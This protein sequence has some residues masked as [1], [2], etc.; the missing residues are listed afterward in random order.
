MSDPGRARFDSLT[1]EVTSLAETVRRTI[2]VPLWQRQGY[3]DIILTKLS[4]SVRVQPSASLQSVT[5]GQERL[6]SARLSSGH[7]NE[8]MAVETENA[9]CSRY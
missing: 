3:A 9:G 6:K 1:N 7:Q 4:G 8:L 2:H 5:Q